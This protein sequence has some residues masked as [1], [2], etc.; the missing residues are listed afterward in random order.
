LE[1]RG[2]CRASFKIILLNQKG[3]K[4][5]DYCSDVKEFSKLDS[6]NDQN[7]FG[8]SKFIYKNDLKNE[9]NGICVNDN[10]VIMKNNKISVFG[11]II[12]FL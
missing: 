5:I 3:W 1:S 9:T 10:I 6:I 8:N 4:N 11:K 7:I 2:T 12:N